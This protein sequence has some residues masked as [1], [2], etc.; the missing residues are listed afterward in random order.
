MKDSDF[1]DLANR[2]IDGV[3]S[4]HDRIALEAVLRDSTHRRLEYD[5]LA[6]VASI[7]SAVRPVEPPADLRDKILS[8][9]PLKVDSEPIWW[10]S[11]AWAALLDMVRARPRL[12]MAYAVV[13]G[14]VVG[15]VGFGAL[16]G[17]L[18]TPESDV[19]GTMTGYEF[20]EGLS[21]VDETRLAEDGLDAIVVLFT[22]AD[23]FRV[24]IDLTTNTPVNVELSTG[25][26]DDRWMGVF[27]ADGSAFSALVG[28]GTASLTG[29]GTGKY[30]FVG[31]ARD[32][33]S[34][35]WRVD[36]VFRTGDGILARTTLDATP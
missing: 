34:S 20:V 29:A 21:R 27:R 14:L 4:E 23:A 6:A 33:E 2:V 19:L 15:M 25:R 7:L 11:A 36:I 12:S 32:Y 22:E 8:S 9:L 13:T 28:E 3:G 18:E 26:E 17:S 10:G 30:A 1:L 35:Q 24:E 5:Q 31:S 16:S